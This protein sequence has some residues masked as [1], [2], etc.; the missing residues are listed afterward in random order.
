MKLACDAGSAKKGR[1]GAIVLQRKVSLAP[2]QTVTVPLIYGYEASTQTDDS[3]ESVIGRYRGRDLRAL[4][5]EQSRLCKAES[6]HFKVESSPEVEREVAWDYGAPPA[7]FSY[8]DFFEGHI[9]T[10]GTA[11]T[12]VNGFNSA[13]RDPLQ[14]A[15]PFIFTRPE[16]AGDVL[17]YTLRE[18]GTKPTETEIPCDF[19]CCFVVFLYC[20]H[21]F[22]TVLTCFVLF[23]L[24]FSGPRSSCM[25][26]SARPLA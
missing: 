5:A 3:A 1:N 9:L 10:Q 6:M 17:K 18:M 23:S 20:F 22:S 11:Y 16:L 15:L 21:L 13:A 26:S 14:H 4:F 2:G 24:L 25:G 12:Y 8:D 7:A 19:Q